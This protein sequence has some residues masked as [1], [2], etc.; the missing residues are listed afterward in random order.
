MCII[1]LFV[2]APLL[3]SIV[4]VW[5]DVIITLLLGFVDFCFVWGLLHG[6]T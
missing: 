6:N 1:Y 5:V 3:G 2:I 4:P